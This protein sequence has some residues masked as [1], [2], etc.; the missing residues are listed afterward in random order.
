MS[1]LYFISY[2]VEI[3]TLLQNICILMKLFSDR[4][5][6]SQNAFEQL[7]TCYLKKIAGIGNFNMSNSLPFYS[8]I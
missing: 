3:E 5:Q 4:K 6:F 2:F 7:F 1:D 8:V